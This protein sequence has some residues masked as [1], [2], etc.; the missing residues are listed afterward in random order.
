[1]RRFLLSLVLGLA[2]FSGPSKA[3]DFPFE[4]IILSDGALLINKGNGQ[5]WI[6]ESGA[7]HPPGMQRS[8]NQLQLPGFSMHTTERNSPHGPNGPAMRGGP[9]GAG[10]GFP[11]PGFPNQDFRGPDFPGHGPNPQ[12]GF[13]PGSGQMT[14]PQMGNRSPMAQNPPN[15]QAMPN[16]QPGTF[17]PPQPFSAAAPGIAPPGSYS[18][19]I[20]MEQMQNFQ[21]PALPPQNS[22][23]SALRTGSP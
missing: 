15:G 20:P 4:T 8:W 16:W 3:G 23:A 1:M 18:L 22:P 5:N 19:N 9:N 21:A 6:M 17:Q 2:V 10:P 13:R 7:P 11:S 14:P 12:G